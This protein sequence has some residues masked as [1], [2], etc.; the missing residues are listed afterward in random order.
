M[1]EKQQTV[2]NGNLSARQPC[3]YEGLFSISPL[4][5]APLAE[6]RL[7]ISTQSIHHRLHA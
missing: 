7:V 4:F 3:V 2:A 1:T 5:D 6:D